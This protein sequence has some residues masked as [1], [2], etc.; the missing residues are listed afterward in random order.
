M[1][2][3]GRCAPL[4]YQA[5]DPKPGSCSCRSR[6]DTVTKE[7]FLLLRCTALGGQALPTSGQ[8]LQSGMRESV[9]Q[10][11]GDYGVGSILL[12]FQGARA[13]HGHAAAPAHPAII[14]LLLLRSTTLQCGDGPPPR[15][16]GA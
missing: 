5:L 11:F 3:R 1:R 9:Q 16:R 12:L 7:R 2:P 15:A 14:L 8:A 4:P 13:P 10:S 6:H